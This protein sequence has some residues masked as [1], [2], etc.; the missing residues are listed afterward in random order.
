M[1]QRGPR[2]GLLVLATGH[3]QALADVSIP[4]AEDLLADIVQS[5][6]AVGSYIEEVIRPVDTSFVTQ[7]FAKTSRGRK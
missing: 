6:L 7:A 3:Q 4:W 5:A 2:A 1:R